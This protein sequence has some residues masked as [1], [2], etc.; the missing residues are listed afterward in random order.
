MRRFSILQPL[1]LSFYSGDL[2]RDVRRN[3]KGTGFLYL[4]LLLALTWMPVMAR[5]HK[6]M[7]EEIRRE[8]PKFVEQVPQVTIVKGEVSIDR[9]VPYTIADPD[10]GTPL[11]VI[12]TSGRTSSLEQTNAPVLLTKNKLMYR[13]QQ[14]SETRIYDLTAIDDLTVDQALVSRWVEEFRRYFAIVAYPFAVAGSFAYRVLQMLLYAAIGM[15]FVSRLKAQLDYLTMLRLASVAITPVVVLS[16]LVKLTGMQIPLAGLVSF[17]I[18]M[19]Y[20]FF[21]VKANADEAG[22]GVSPPAA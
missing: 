5:L 20:L 3:W 6:E 19:G 17:A 11:L 13:Q 16:T 7:S 8:A 10:T 4:L 2:Y 12:D 1:Y 15:L 21:A 9:K 18:A 22:P 14:R